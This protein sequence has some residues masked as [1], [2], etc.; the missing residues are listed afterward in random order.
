MSFNKDR[1]ETTATSKAEAT[2][3][4]EELNALDLALRQ[5]AQPGLIKSTTAGLDLSQQLLTGGELPGSLAG[6]SGGISPEVTQDIVDRSL[7][8]VASSAQLGG[9]LDSG[10]A[11]E[12]GT[13]AAADVRTQ[14]EQF[15]IQNLLQLLNLAVGG[16]AQAQSGALGTGATLGSRLAGLRP[17]TQ[18]QTTTST[19]SFLTRNIQAA[20]ALIP[21]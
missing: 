12:L 21:G 4:E 1:E 7:Q 18:Q 3:Q 9:F 8:D 13:R 20:N 2:S 19:P 14:S 10:V 17:L 16:Q 11:Q 15:N 5:A 6:L